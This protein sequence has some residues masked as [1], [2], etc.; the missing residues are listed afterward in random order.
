MR[1]VADTG[2][3]R[4]LSPT[5]SMKPV[6]PNTAF[7]QLLRTTPEYRPLF[8]HLGIDPLR[9]PNQSLAEVCHAH[10]L[11]PRTVARLLSAFTK[12]VAPA[13]PMKLMLLSELCDHL[14]K[15]QHAYLHDELQK[16]DLMTRTAAKQKGE[17]N[18]QLLIIREAFI[19]LRAQLTAHLL[20][21]AKDLFPMIRLLANG[22]N[23]E[24]PTRSAVKFR[25]TRMEHEHNQI[26]EALAELGLLV[27]NKSL[28]LQFPAVT[29]TMAAAIARLEHTVHE[30]IYHENQ[31]LFP[32]ALAC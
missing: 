29:R 10:Q 9:N 17:A 21:E 25:L 14:E 6:N 31:V 13:A 8:I 12:T 22:D 23:D 18:P 7:N 20:A 24:R 32:R 1:R 26:D 4:T 15:P 11:E 16:L 3:A 27:A 28:E 5:I 2:L 30:Q 19:A